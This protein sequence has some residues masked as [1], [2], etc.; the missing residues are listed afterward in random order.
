MLLG[1]LELYFHSTAS[2]LS[3]MSQIVCMGGRIRCS[4]TLVCACVEEEGEGHSHNYL[5]AATM[6]HK[7]ERL[8]PYQMHSTQKRA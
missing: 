1:S 8:T 5:P 2:L 4:G 3:P 7:N 6:V